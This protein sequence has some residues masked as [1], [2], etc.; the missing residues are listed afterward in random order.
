M[1]PMTRTDEIQALRKRVEEATWPDRELDIALIDFACEQFVKR[2]GWT[3]AK[4]GGD[5]DG[6]NACDLYTHNGLLIPN[7]DYPR[8]GKVHPFFHV[9][10]KVLPWGARGFRDDIKAALAFSEELVPG[11]FW[12][13]GKGRV[14]A[15]EPL[16]AFQLMF[17]TEQVL[18]EAEA[19]SPET[20]ILAA[21]LRALEETASG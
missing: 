12:M 9:R 3:L 15:A 17:G 10:D 20:A 13:M 8:K 21:T 11:A 4:L 14:R 18:G 2:R 7:F 19:N 5:Y 1:T 16:Y 6:E